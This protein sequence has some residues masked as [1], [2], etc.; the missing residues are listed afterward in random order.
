[1]GKTELRLDSGQ[2]SLENGGERKD[3]DN[4]ELRVESREIFYSALRIV[5]RIQT[6]TSVSITIG[7]RVKVIEIEGNNIVRSSGDR[8]NHNAQRSSSSISSRRYFSV[9]ARTRSLCA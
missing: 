9:R 8:L 4:I 6:A 5:I 2:K 3:P 7:T 1:V